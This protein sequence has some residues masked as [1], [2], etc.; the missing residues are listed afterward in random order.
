MITGAGAILQQQRRLSVVGHD[1]VE[2]AVIVEVANREAT[3]G[4]CLGERG[5]GLGADVAQLAALVVEKQQRLLVFHLLRVLL[6]HVVGVTVRQNQ[7]DR[8]VVVV[9][10]E[11][12]APP[13]EQPRRLRDAVGV[14]GVAEILLLAVL[15]Q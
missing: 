6:D 8:A 10:E 9:I 5:P 11:F 15:V 3:R 7:V 14:R 12:E 13:A 2:P 4:V 1:H